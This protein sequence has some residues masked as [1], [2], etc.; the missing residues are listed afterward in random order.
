M[1]PL[2]FG[3]NSR[4]IMR[5]GTGIGRRALSAFDA[6]L[7]DAGLGHYNLLK[8]SS[9]LPP[10]AVRGEHLPLSAGAQ[11][12]IAYAAEVADEPGDRICAAAAVAIP[13]DR[14]QHGVIMEYHARGTGDDAERIVRDMAAEAM[15]RRNHLIQEIVSTSIEALSGE[16]PTAV[17]AGAALVPAEVYSR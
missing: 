13:E 8:V 5:R 16:E 7:L 6:A 2:I 15:E 11:L 14:E 10:Q 12:P 4:F 9:V 1:Q 3:P 17:F